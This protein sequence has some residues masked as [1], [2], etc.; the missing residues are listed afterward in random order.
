MTKQ[1]CSR[2]TEKRMAG[3]NGRYYYRNRGYYPPGYYRSNT[4]EAV[5][6]GALTGVATGALVASLANSNSQQPQNNTTTT[7]NYYA[8]PYSNAYPPNYS[9][10][11]P[12][13][14]PYSSYSNPY[15]ETQA[16]P[17]YPSYPMSTTTTTR[18]G[19]KEKGRKFKNTKTYYESKYSKMSSL[20]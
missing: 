14:Y 10:P 5:A 12:Y 11:Y 15:Y 6:L 19:G 17:S 7:T 8:N 4:G 16:P 9:Y 13:P 20:P 3:H 1:L 18:T 2:C